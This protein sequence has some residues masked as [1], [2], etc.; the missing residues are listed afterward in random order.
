MKDTV[1]V[2]ID[3]S[4]FYF[5]LKNSNRDKR[6]N[7]F[8]LGQALAGPERKLLR[9]YYY[10]VAHDENSTISQE[11]L[12]AERSFH[13]SLDMTPFIELRLGRI[14]SKRVADSSV[15]LEKGVDIRMATDMVYGAAR[16][17][18]DTAI[19]ITEDKDFSVVFK[20]VKDFGRQVEL[21]IWMGSGPLS[22]L[23]RSADKVVDLGFILD[24]NP[25]I[26]G[27]EP[28]SSKRSK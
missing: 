26:L 25:R 12:K 5:G 19:V 4:S 3:G 9:V 15:F 2:F 17:F 18:F 27:T 1:A 6:T 11:A 23:T 16:G 10:N 14:I 28:I 22:D 8:E 21:G 20:A 13:D 7:Y 24:G